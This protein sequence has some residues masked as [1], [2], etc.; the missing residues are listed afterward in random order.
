MSGNSFPTGDGGHV[1]GAVAMALDEDGN[2]VPIEADTPI[3]TVKLDLEELCRVLAAHA[4]IV[5]GGGDMEEV[6]QAILRFAR[7]VAP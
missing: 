7:K 5:A 1:T 4:C 6:A 3:G 2:A